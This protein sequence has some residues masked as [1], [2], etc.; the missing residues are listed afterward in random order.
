MVPEAC[1]FWCLLNTFGGSGAV[2]QIYGCPMVFLRFSRFG[3]VGKSLKCHTDFAARSE[4][5]SWPCFCII[6]GDVGTPLGPKGFPGSLNYAKKLP[7]V[8]LPTISAAPSIHQSYNSSLDLY[9]KKEERVLEARKAREKMISSL[10][11]S[12]SLEHLKVQKKNKKVIDGNS[13]LKVKRH[14]SERST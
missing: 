8:V 2:I 10:V 4:K 11:K 3:R 5:K 14:D 9:T 1:S 6:L 12:A 13:L 7:K